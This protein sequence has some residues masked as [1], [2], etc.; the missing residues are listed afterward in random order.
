MASGF[1][2]TTRLRGTPFWRA[3]AMDADDTPLRAVAQAELEV[4]GI[5]RLGDEVEPARPI[6]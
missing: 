5:E 2:A 4:S 3:M 6:E 1:S